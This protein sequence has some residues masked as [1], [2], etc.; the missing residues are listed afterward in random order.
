MLPGIDDGAKDL[1]TTLQMARLAVADGIT[2]TVCTPHIYPGR[3]DN[4]HA[5]IR[6]ACE[7]LQ[8]ELL[9]ANIPLQLAYGADIQVA[10]ELTQRL[11]DGSLPTLHSSRYFLF[12]PPHHVSLPQ[13]NDMIE[14]ALNLGFVPV[15]THP[16]RLFYVETDY[17]KFVEAARSGAWIQLT[18]GSL[19]GRFGRRAKSVS[20]R[21]LRDGITHLLASDGHNLKNRTPELAKARDAAARLVG[22]EEA[23]RLVRLRPA[24]VIANEAPDNIPLPPGLGPNARAAAPKKQAWFTRLFSRPPTA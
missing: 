7:Q 10:P 1:D 9:A 19:L 24:A 6:E 3:F 20:E 8:R 13:L 21:F 16:E 11:L 22:A 15:I 14:E 18:G 12:E 17:D 5:G 23:D 2:M 4:T